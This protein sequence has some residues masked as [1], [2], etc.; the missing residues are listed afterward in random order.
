MPRK[1]KVA[2]TGRRTTRRQLLGGLGSIA[3]ASAVPRP[4]HAA[5]PS[6]MATLSSYMAAAATRPLP[7]DVIEEAKKHVLD[8]LGAAVSGTKLVPGIHALR[9]AEILGRQDNA[10]VFAS[11]IRLAPIDAALING[12]LSNADETDDNYSTGGAHPGCA[13]V[14]AAFAM[15][16]REDADGA[17][18]LR[19]VVLGYDIGMRAFKVVAKGN[20]LDETHNIVGT[21]G[22][23]AAAASV[24][25]LDAAQM[26]I[27]IDYASQQAG[28]GIGAWREDTE[29]VEKSFM[30]GG[31]GARNGVTAALL[32]KTGWSG[33]NDVLSGPGNFFQSYA[34][35]VDPAIFVAG[36][37]E[38]YEIKGTIIKKWSTGGPVQSPLDAFYSIR[39][40]K[41]F[42]ADDVKQVVVRIATSA[43]DKVSDSSM[44]NLS[45]QYMIALMLLDGTV[46]FEASHDEARRRTPEIQRQ[47]AKVKVIADEAIEKLLPQRVGI[48]EITFN[49][50]SIETERNDV[51]RGSPENPMSFEEVAAKALDLMSPV[52]G[53]AKS[54]ALIMQVHDLDRIGSIRGLRENLQISA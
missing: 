28:A 53:P 46:N 29:H 32:A 45:M 11:R 24:A 31:M 19:A 8:T 23:A 50:G 37:G 6:V 17:R 41:A 52:L 38:T 36:L 25:A 5:G 48:V 16:E 2:S 49:D 44:A 21:M 39:Q 30:F 1:M 7:Q 51:V 10:T 4:G 13:I 43:Y 54:R 22:A 26:R 35:K 27:L 18:F 42:K 33:V 47:A 9:L 3:A 34:P 14:P 15:G 40:R 20:V 12:I